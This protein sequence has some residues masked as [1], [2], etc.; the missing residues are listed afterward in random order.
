MDAAMGLAAAGGLGVAF[1]V[2]Y[3]VLRKYTYP[4]VKEPFFSD[5]TLFILFTVGLIEGTILFV[6]W[7]Y[8]LP[9]YT[10]PGLGLV[11]A[12]LFGAI[13]EFVK[14]VT[15]N[16]KR[17]AGISDT[18]FYGFGLGIGMGA[19]TAFG[20]IFYWTNDKM[21]GVDV[22]TYIIVFALAIMNVLLYSGNGIFVG[23]GVARRKPWEYVIKAMLFNALFQ[24]L[25]VPFYL[26]WHPWYFITLAIAFA[27]VV[28]VFYDTVYKKLPYEVDEILRQNGK[29]RSDIPG[30]R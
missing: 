14:L 24:A 6:V 19:A 30:L 29:K 28:Y 5:P 26:A 25:L 15:L 4:K 12:I 3:L 21:L 9:F 17:F 13:T 11:I 16:L 23:E 22:M 18:I 20:T 7:S 8:L 10:V 2:M 27:L 1:V